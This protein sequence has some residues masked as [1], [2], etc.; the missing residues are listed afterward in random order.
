MQSLMCIFQEIAPSGKCY[1]EG[2]GLTKGYWE[3]P[4]DVA[5]MPVY[6]KK[7]TQRV[8]SM[9]LLDSRALGCISGLGAGGGGVEALCCVSSQNPRRQVAADF[10]ELLFQIP[11]GN[12]VSHQNKSLIF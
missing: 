5:K 12:S 7:E 4:R 9:C 8:S 11:K 10:G 3:S 2:D 1:C 6:K